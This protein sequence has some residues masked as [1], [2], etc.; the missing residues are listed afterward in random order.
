MQW[1]PDYVEIV[2]ERARRINE[3]RRDPRIF[4]GI[5]KVYKNH[6]VEFIEDWCTTYDPRNAGTDRPVIMPFALFPRQRE[7]IDFFYAC[8]KAPA[9]GL[10]EKSRDM[11]ATWLACAFSVWLWLYWPG[12]AIGWGSRK[13]PLVDHLGD[14]DS[15]FE[16]M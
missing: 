1:P 14:S 6:P 2:A 7:L 15:I 13:Q 16:K 3:F 5:Q 8:L 4:I 11:G 12:A 10:V 9:N